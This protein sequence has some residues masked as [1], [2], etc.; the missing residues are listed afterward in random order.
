MD[1]QTFLQFSGTLT[2][3]DP[4][5]SA[6]CS[7]SAFVI[8]GTHS[9]VGKTTVTLGLLAA[10]RR[11]GI[12]V[13]PFKIGPD[14][15]DPGLHR[16]AAEEISYNLDGWM[17]TRES[18]LRSFSAHS[19]RK[20][21]AVVE[22]VMGLFDGYD[23]K[24]ERGSTAEMAKWLGLPVLL[25]VDASA[26][27]RS[28]AALVLGFLRFDP[29]LK[30]LGIIFNRIGG[31]G[32]LRYL[33]E[34]MAS[35][36]ATEV[37]GGLPYDERITI[38][39]RHLGLVTAEEA[40]MNQKFMSHLADWIEKHLDLKRLLKKSRV[41]LPTP[42]LRAENKETGKQAATIGIAHDEA[43][44]F[45][46][47]DNLSLLKAAGA[48]LVPFS[49]VRDRALP[50]N[51][52]ALYLGGGYPELHARALAQNRF[53]RESIQNFIES[54]GLVYAEC[55]GFM[56]LTEALIDQRREQFSM[57]G[58]YPVKTR[59][60]SQLKALGY[61]EVKIKSG[62]FFPAG[63]RARGHEFHYSELDG[64]LGRNRE[65]KTIYLVSVK[66][67]STEEGFLYKNCLASYV[68]LHF[69]SSPGMAVR[70]VEACR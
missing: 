15:I 65:I 17:L 51:I 41:K 25:V 34:A 55:G 23:G 60:L 31:E 7:L 68:H 36:P 69:G 50:P 2:T 9:G 52:K 32:H 35:L 64:D 62:S 40:F 56:Y 1:T 6:P 11:R 57:V 70:L 59:M 45:Y 4:A 38:R 26:M 10:L 46:Y 12:K 24:S 67:K 42:K 28:A 29:K 53:M 66:G 21:V 30:I 20:E 13:Q 44:C 8:G 61:R 33:K 49:P 3:A 43:F 54:G 47:P 18:N 5:Q 16:Q 37:F 19:Q 22:G 63:M 39:E 48:R 27:A 14:F 58:I